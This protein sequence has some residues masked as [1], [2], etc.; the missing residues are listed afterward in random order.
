MNGKETAYNIIVLPVSPINL[1]DYSCS[2]SGTKK[3]HHCTGAETLYTRHIHSTLYK[4]YNALS[5][6][7]TRCPKSFSGLYY[8]AVLITL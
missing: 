8:S 7:S 2:R 4:F 5:S 3:N 1:G 6:I